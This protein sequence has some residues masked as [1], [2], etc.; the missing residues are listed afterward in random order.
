MQCINPEGVYAVHS[1]TGSLLTNLYFVLTIQILLCII[2]AALIILWV[3][4]RK[5]VSKNAN[6]KKLD[7]QV[8][9]FW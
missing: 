5:K 4:I 3:H 7:T 8:K 9:K 6:V 1:I 2:E